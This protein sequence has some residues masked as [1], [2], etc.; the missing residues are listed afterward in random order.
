M[1]DCLDLF[2]FSYNFLMRE[3]CVE[4][5]VIGIMPYGTEPATFIYSFKESVASLSLSLS[6]IADSTSFVIYV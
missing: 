5:I 4:T 3:L 6:R 2:T 1:L